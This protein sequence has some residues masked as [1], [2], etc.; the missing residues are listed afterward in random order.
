[1]SNETKADA[2]IDSVIVTAIKLQDLSNN[3]VSLGDYFDEIKEV[4]VILNNIL[5]DC[6]VTMWM[7]ECVC[8]DAQEEGFENVDEVNEA[9][10]EHMM[11]DHYWF[12]YEFVQELSPRAKNRG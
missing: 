5:D 8:C 6:G 4:D 3:G 7:Y 12:T 1:M 2:F 10:M 9:A 11:Q